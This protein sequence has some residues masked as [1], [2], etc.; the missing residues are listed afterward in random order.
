VELAV[1]GSCRVP[2]LYT[3]ADRSNGR[4]F[5]TR[6]FLSVVCL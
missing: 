6:L 5:A 4:A 1:V 2:L 3:L